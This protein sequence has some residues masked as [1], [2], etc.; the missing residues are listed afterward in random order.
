MT[1]SARFPRRARLLK[2]AEFKATFARG[3]RTHERGLTVIAVANTLGHPRLGLAV[4]KKAVAL[5]AERNRIKRQVRESFRLH[6]H[7]LPAV[8]LVVLVKP[9]SR[10]LTTP[11]LRPSLERLWIRVSA[12]LAASSPAAS[13]ALRSS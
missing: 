2:P 8:D 12:T 6:Q 1:T 3:T 11:Q 4:A 9:G 13:P 5:A 7:Q 10:M